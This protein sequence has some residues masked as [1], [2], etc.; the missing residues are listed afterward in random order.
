MDA[1]KAYSI[2]IKGLQNGIHQFVFHID[3]SFFEHFENTPI[4]DSNI[5]MTLSFDKRSDMFVLHFDFQGTVNTNCDRCLA[6]I[7]L[8][9][10]DKQRLLVKFSETEEMEEA[11]VIFISRED[12]ELNVAKYIYEYICL[13]LPPDK[14]L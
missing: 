9:L 1:L 2:P 12:H 3:K 13:A 7:D 5:E 6:K 8:P 11:D 14:K 10:A 4:E